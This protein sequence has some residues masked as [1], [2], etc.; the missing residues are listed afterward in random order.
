MFET[1]GFLFNQ[2]SCLHMSDVLL[3]DLQLRCTLLLHSVQTRVI[4]P[5]CTASSLGCC[6]G[7]DAL[8]TLG[9]PTACVTVPLQGL[10][11]LPMWTESLLYA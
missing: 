8:D 7:D 1:K 10:R 2:T 5:Q 4:F 11:S 3:S 9:F 6:S